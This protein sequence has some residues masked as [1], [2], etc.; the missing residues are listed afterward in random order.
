MKPVKLSAAGEEITGKL[1]LLENTGNERLLRNCNPCL[2]NRPV[3]C[4]MWTCLRVTLLLATITLQMP[5]DHH[6]DAYLV[7]RN[8]AV[9]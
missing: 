8:N 1:P 7:Q 3:M 5:I 6:T 4:S 2:P 9:T